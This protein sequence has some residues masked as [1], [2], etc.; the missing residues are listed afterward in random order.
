MFSQMQEIFHALIKITFS[1]YMY[2]LV[3]LLQLTQFYMYAYLFYCLFY[4]FFPDYQQH[5]INKLL[6]MDDRERLIITKGF[7]SINCVWRDGS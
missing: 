3:S 2:S 4:L 6:D 1:M 7:A 5:P